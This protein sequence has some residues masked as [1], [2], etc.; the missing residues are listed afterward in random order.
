MERETIVNRREYSI[1]FIKICS[2][3]GVVAAHTLRMDSGLVNT[4]IVLATSMGIPLFFAVN[5]YLMFQKQAISYSYVSKK[6]V[7]ILGVCLGWEIMY[8]LAYFI[9]YHEVRNFIKSF[10]MDFF[11][12]GL[13]F[14]FWFMG[15]LLILLLMLPF[16]H[17]YIKSTCFSF[18]LVACGIICVTID[19]LMLFKDERFILV[20]PQNLRVWMW[21]FY[22]LL[23]GYI[24]K[25]TLRLKKII[26]RVSRPA[27]LFTVFVSLVIVVIWQ[28]LLKNRCS[29][30]SFESNY[31]SIPFIFSVFLIVSW[32]MSTSIQFP[33]VGI[34]ISKCVMGIYI[35]HPF[36]LSVVA[37]IWPAFVSGGSV[38]NLL[39]WCITTAI[40][41]AATYIILRIPF[42]NCL[43]KL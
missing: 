1:D 21:L 14:H 40:S 15:A 37:K 23:G 11:Q 32:G 30:F 13:F 28:L 7:K 24:A 19:A 33:P 29:S 36:V 5:G 42:I 22:Y 41:F 18:I 20:L 10:I 27:F 39:Y 35:L 6:V 8:S 12:Q 26:A 34:E 31:G 9:V 3:L 16:L 17:R 2:C 25:N 4:I 43:V 38:M